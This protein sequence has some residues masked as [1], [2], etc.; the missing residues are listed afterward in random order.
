MNPIQQNKLLAVF[1]SLCLVVGLW[2][3][4]VLAAEEDSMDSV[5]CETSGDSMED[6]AESSSE[7]LL[8]QEVPEASNGAENTLVP[9]AENEMSGFCGATETDTVAWRLEQ[10][11][12]DSQNPTYTLILDGA[13]VM[14]DYL[15]D[16]TAAWC[17]ALPTYQTAIT[18][19]VIGKDITVIGQCAFVGCSAVTEVTFEEGSQLREIRLNGFPLMTALREI[20]L[21][22]TLE[23]L[24]VSAFYGCS[25]LEKVILQ[26]PDNLISIG[27]SAFGRCSSL[28]YFNNPEEKQDCEIMPRFL[29]TI[30]ANAFANCSQMIGQITIPAGVESLSGS[31]LAC[32]QI[33]KISFESG[34]HLKLIDKNTFHSM[35]G[36]SE[37]TLPEELETIGD[38]A[39]WGCTSLETVI[40]KNPDKLTA[41]VGGAFG[42]C[43]S[44]KYFNNP[45][46]KQ[47]C[48]IMPSS[49]TKI[50]LSA[51]AYIHPLRFL[52]LYYY[53]AL[54]LCC[55][56]L[57]PQ[58]TAGACGAA[59]W[60][61][62]GK[63]A[64]P[65]AA[66]PPTDQTGYFLKI[67]KID[68]GAQN[69]VVIAAVHPAAGDD[70]V[71]P[72]HI[73]WAYAAML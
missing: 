49:V 35:T 41:I 66:L 2:P 71:L 60:E 7:E 11:N 24:D 33:S 12:E 43:S 16:G 14:I 23:A 68:G 38:S 28:K 64:A 3:A 17:I 27:V 42:R 20:T 39:F 13:G 36:I 59:C 34:S 50:C 52:S 67:T 65:T 8:R 47:D 45:E 32:S 29:K 58:H 55:Q 18:K 5:V 21:P 48:E 26:N 56:M 4:A 10:N 61:D 6:E 63:A 9:L 44:L 72:G 54:S 22:G 62:A 25:S 51:I 69:S 57:A 37:I 73:L 30:G 53:N 40:L 19:I 1:L 70:A 31:F 15:K 46:K